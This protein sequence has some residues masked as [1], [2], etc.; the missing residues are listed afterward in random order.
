MDGRTDPN[1]RNASLKHLEY[2]YKIGIMTNE[3]ILYAEKLY[4]SKYPKT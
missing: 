2:S 1:Y 3:N 4:C